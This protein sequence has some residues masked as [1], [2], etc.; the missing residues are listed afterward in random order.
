[1]KRIALVIAV[2]VFAVAGA[3]AYLLSNL[4]SVVKTAIENYG[5][6]AA[7][8]P[9]RITAVDIELRSGH[10]SLRGLTVGNPA[11]FSNSTALSVGEII[12]ALD[13][14]GAR[15]NPVVISQITAQSPSVT[16]ELGAEGSNLEALERNV[17]A[18]AAQHRDGATTTTAGSEAGSGRRVVIDRLSLTNGT[19]N[20]ATPMPGGAA[21][22]SLGDIT[23]TQIGETTGGADWATV[24][25][26][27]LDAVSHA[28]ATQVTSL[29]PKKLLDSM[30]ASDA[31]APLKN[32]FGK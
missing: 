12:L 1:M 10:G 15:R 17:K 6:K 30:S 27:V 3:A 22:L 2:L 5:S 25:S 31:T 21:S 18:F 19:V 24:A 13:V 23:L 28:A 4:D 20:L 29:N 9:V 7:G 16:Y 8:A 32:L 11:G 26:T 14:A